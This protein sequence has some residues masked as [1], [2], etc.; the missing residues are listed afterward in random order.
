[1]LLALK[2]LSVPSEAGVEV[3]RMLVAP[4]LPALS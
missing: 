3:D 4:M 1:M 2:R